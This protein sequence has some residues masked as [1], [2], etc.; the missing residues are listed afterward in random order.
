MKKYYGDKDKIIEED[1][2][3][4]GFMALDKGSV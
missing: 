2:E 4:L 1:Q 3:P